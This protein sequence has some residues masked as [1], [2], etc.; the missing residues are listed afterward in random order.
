MNWLQFGRDAIL[1]VAITMPFLAIGLLI[2]VVHKQGKLEK[3]GRR[4]IR[5]YRE[6]IIEELT[7]RK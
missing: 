4:L 6:A 5:E 3:E 2:R 7:R 1:V